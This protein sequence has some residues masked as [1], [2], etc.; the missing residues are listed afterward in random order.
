MAVLVR[1]KFGMRPCHLWT[2]DMCPPIDIL[3][4]IDRAIAW[5]G[6]LSAPDEHAIE[7]LKEARAKIERMHLFHPQRVRHS[8]C[9]AGGWGEGVNVMKIDSTDSGVF[10]V[11]VSYDEPN[12]CRANPV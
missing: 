10:A 9:R 7:V 2:A 5:E 11:K 12:L 3:E 1:L 4:K 8:A 6:E